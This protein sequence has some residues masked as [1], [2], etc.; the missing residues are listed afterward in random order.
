[1]HTQK[2]RQNKYFPTSFDRPHSLIGLCDNKCGACSDE[3]RGRV[4]LRIGKGCVCERT[5]SPCQHIV[6]TPSG[7]RLVESSMTNRSYKVGKHFVL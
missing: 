4:R 5:Y 3:S 2:F 7:V 1:M 6:V